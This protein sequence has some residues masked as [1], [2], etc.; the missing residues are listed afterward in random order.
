MKQDFA[1]HYIIF[2]I[3]SDSI[4]ALVFEKI[5]NTKTKKDSY[6]EIFTVRKNINTQQGFS[7]D[8]FFLRTLSVFNDVAV[9]AHKY[10]GNNIANIYINI[11]APWVSSQKRVLHYKKDKEFVFTK[12][13]EKQIL[14]KELEKSLKQTYDFKDFNNLEL[15][16]QRTLDIYANGYPARSPYGKSVLDVDIHSLVSVMSADTKQSFNHVVERNFHR[17]AVFF[18]NTLMG[19]DSLTQLF[20]HENNILSMDIS[21]EV[22]EISIIIDDH[23]KKNGVVPFGSAGVI[24]KLAELLQIPYQ[25]AESLM[26]LYQENHL[27]ENYRNQVESAMKKAFIFWFKEI[28]SFLGTVSAEHKIP[29]TIMLLAPENIQNWFNEW[30]LKTEEIKEHFSGQKPIAL[31]DISSKFRDKNNMQFAGISD[32]NLALALWFVE[33]SFL[34]K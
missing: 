2:D 13:I 4:G 3:D 17:D 6:S 30:L 16:E 10:S 25:K 29:S 34:K 21:G 19:Y 14:E 22:T 9:A 5:L 7:F 12:D 33:N 23:L 18:S 26:V 31:L 28:Y 15:V 11:S 32:E 24:R 27:E 20:P 1:Q 8:M